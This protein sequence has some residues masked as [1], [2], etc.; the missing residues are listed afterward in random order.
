MLLGV[1]A[2]CWAT[3][4][5]RA[6]IIL[7]NPVYETNVPAATPS[8]YASAFGAP[9]PTAAATVLASRGQAASVS[10]TT[11]YQFA[12]EGPAG[13]PPTV[14]I[15]ITSYVQYGVTGTVANN[16]FNSTEW[17]ADAEVDLNGQVLNTAQG[18]S[19]DA[20]SL[21]Q[22]FLEASAVNVLSNTVY[23]VQVAAIVGADNT[24]ADASTGVFAF[25]NPMI[26]FAPGFNSTGDTLI[27]SPGIGD[28][29]IS[30][31]PPS[32]TPE[33]ATLTLLGLGAAGLL[34]HTWRVCRSQRG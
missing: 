13:I 3:S 9:V 2:V 10:A 34:G 28:G 27:F 16:G 4:A 6:G 30:E 12:V 1:A 17:N 22:S 24:Y 21:D 25:A 32:A 33:P 8:D 18:A 19:Y 23:D 20:S 26:S 14:P 29:P 15:L 7:S 11:S 31:T 5:A